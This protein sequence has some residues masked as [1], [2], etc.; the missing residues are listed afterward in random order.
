[1]A[2]TN[3]ERQAKWRQNLRAKAAAGVSIDD[4]FREKL[5]SVFP[6]DWS[7]WGE[8]DEGRFSVLDQARDEFLGMSDDELT[9]WFSEAVEAWHE[10]RCLKIF[11]EMQQLKKQQEREE[12]R[13]TKRGEES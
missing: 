4:A 9:K 12:K 3:R 6:K 11:R 8:E 7:E 10:S 2:M 1:M 13:K 5:R